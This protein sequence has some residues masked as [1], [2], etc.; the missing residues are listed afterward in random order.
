MDWSGKISHIEFGKCEEDAKEPRS[1][2]AN[3]DDDDDDGCRFIDH[4]SISF[5]IFTTSLLSGKR[6]HI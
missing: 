3:D 2:T 4:Y 1:A 5:E 6:G